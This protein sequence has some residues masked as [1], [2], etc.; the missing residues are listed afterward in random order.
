MYKNKTAHTITPTNN[1][2]MH[3]SNPVYDKNNITDN[4]DLDEIYKEETCDNSVYA[5]P[6]YSDEDE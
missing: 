5:D 1:S 3:F 4:D 6:S 2:N